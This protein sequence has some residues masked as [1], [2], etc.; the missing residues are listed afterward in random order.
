MDADVGGPTYASYLLQQAAIEDACAS[1]CTHYHM[2]ES[3]NAAS[4]AQFKRAFGAEAY[5]YAEYRF[6]RI[7]LTSAERLLRS[8]AE[9]GRSLRQHRQDVAAG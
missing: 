6:E 5:D 7:P 4:L 8:Y 9:R 1:G 2:G 3:G